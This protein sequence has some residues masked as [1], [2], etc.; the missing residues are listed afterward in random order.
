M[1]TPSSFIFWA[2]QALLDHWGMEDGEVAGQLLEL[3]QSSQA[4]TVG[5]FLPRIIRDP[6]KCHERLMTLLRDPSLL[7]A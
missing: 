5:S 6:L 3:A 7:A 4:A 2:V 1:K